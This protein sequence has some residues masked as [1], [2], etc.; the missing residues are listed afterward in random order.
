MGENGKGGAV[1]GRGMGE[2]GKGGAGGGP[3]NTEAF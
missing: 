2:N 1:G 3:P